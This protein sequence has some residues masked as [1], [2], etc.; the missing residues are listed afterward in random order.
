ML[1][2]QEHATLSLL[3]ETRARE[4][5]ILRA[6]GSRSGALLFHPTCPCSNR[7]VGKRGNIVLQ[8]PSLA[9]VAE[10]GSALQHHTELAAMPVG[11]LST[12][13]FDSSN[14]R[15]QVL[16]WSRSQTPECCGPG[17]LRVKAFG[18]PMNPTGYFI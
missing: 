16:L 11:L 17:H 1:L 14:Q 12:A 9:A 10:V 18:R 8:T 13:Q 3:Q 15:C 6:T 7:R 2:E 5:T 4:E